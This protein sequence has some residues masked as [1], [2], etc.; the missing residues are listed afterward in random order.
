MWEITS[1]FFPISKP[2]SHRNI[3]RLTILWLARTLWV[4]NLNFYY[5]RYVSLG[6]LLAICCSVFLC[7][8]IPWLEGLPTL[9]FPPFNPSPLANYPFPKS[10]SCNWS[11]SLCPHSLK[12]VLKRIVSTTESLLPAQNIFEAKSQKKATVII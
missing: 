12:M 8:N 5:Y 4:H 1:S 11:C 10:S 9:E 3:P 6:K 7:L 2:I